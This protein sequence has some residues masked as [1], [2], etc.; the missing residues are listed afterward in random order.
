MAFLYSKSEKVK[1]VN[2]GF[3]DNSTHA[4][5]ILDNFNENW[6]DYYLRK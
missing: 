2:T 3:L 6:S 4:V 1:T 5:K